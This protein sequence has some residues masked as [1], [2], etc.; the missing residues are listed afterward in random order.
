MGV[1]DLSFG[2]GIVGK[3]VGWVDAR[4]VASWSGRSLLCAKVEKKAPSPQLW[5]GPFDVRRETLAGSSQA[6]KPAANK[7]EGF[8][9]KVHDSK[10][11]ESGDESRLG[12]PL[13]PP[14]IGT[15]R[16]LCFRRR[17][18]VYHP[19]ASGYQRLAFN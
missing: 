6:K 3:G 7:A 19:L 15:M 8:A 2:A 1:Y 16:I 18:G 9:K 12:A 5:E 10:I 11:C 14:G 13:R 4:I 17:T